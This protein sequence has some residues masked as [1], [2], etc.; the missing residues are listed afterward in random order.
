MVRGSVFVARVEPFGQS[1][2]GMPVLVRVETCVLLRGVF[3]DRFFDQMHCT[4]P[5]QGGDLAATGHLQIV[6]IDQRLFQAAAAHQ[7]TMIAQQGDGFVGLI[8]YGKTQYAFRTQGRQLVTA[9]AQRGRKRLKRM[10][11]VMPHEP[12]L[13][14]G[15]I[16]AEKR[17][18]Y[19]ETMI[20]DKELLKKKHKNLY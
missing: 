9:S 18:Q 1:H 15:V 10:I 4:A 14:Q 17:I 7:R 5:G 12:L 16:M 6:M 13:R 2:T 20:Q 3:A 19:F 8:R 11:K